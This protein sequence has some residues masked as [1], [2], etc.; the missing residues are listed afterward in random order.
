M[1][2][3]SIQSIISDLTTNGLYDFLKQETSIS[4]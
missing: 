3:D 1:I 4:S 2:K